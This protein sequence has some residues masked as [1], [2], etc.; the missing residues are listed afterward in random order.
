MEALQI[1]I[2]DQDVLRDG[3]SGIYYMQKQWRQLSVSD[4]ASDLQGWHGR[5]VSPTYARTRIITIE[6]IIDRKTENYPN[7]EYSATEY[8]EK[9]FRLQA[10][11]TI[12]EPLDLYVRDVYDRE[13]SLK[14]KVKEPFEVVEGSPDFKWSHWNWRVT[15]ESVWDPTY[16][17][18]YESSVAWAEG[19]YGWFTLD[20]P[21]PFTMESILNSITVETYWNTATFPRIEVTVT[22]DIATPFRVRNMTTGDVFSLGVTATIGDTIIIDSENMKCYK[23]WVDITASRLIGSVWPKIIDTTEFILEDADGWILG[24]DFN[25]VIYYK[26][27]LL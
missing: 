24:S 20:T 26:N 3:A 27:S 17:T 1:K 23:N 18:P 9:L 8:L 12:L 25:A 15:L 16:R 5:I 21:F 22:G 14:V 7:I 6:G 13:W 4:N 19:S 10:D 2:N 11:P